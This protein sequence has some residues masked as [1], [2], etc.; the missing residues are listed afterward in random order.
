MRP[1]AKEEVVFM[2]KN[3]GKHYIVSQD[4]VVEVK[5]FRDYIQHEIVDDLI[6]PSFNGSLNSKT[7]Q[8]FVTA[9]TFDILLPYSQILNTL[10]E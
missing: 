3:L 7:L 2:T 10:H 4:Q 6:A 5:I 1:T 8:F 9:V